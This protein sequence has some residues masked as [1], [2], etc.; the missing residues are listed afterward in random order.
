MC[1]KWANYVIEIDIRTEVR[2]TNEEL[3]RSRAVPVMRKSEV[4]K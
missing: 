1:V 4:K 2:R 3:S